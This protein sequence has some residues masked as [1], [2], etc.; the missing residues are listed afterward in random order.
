MAAHADKHLTV[1]CGHTH[2]PGICQPL[3]NVTVKTRG[4]VRGDPRLHEVIRGCTR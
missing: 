2:R 4:A 1:L 3:P